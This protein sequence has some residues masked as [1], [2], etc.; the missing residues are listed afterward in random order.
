M[1]TLWACGV[2]HGDGHGYGHAALGTAMGMWRWAC[3]SDVALRKGVQSK[4]G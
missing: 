4:G 3:G 1:N 2:G